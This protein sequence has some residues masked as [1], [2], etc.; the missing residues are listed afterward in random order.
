MSNTNRTRRLDSIVQCASDQSG[1]AGCDKS[2]QTR[3]TDGGAEIM[4]VFCHR[5]KEAPAMG[6]SAP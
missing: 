2:A 1:A 6:A 3:R 5:D 4:F